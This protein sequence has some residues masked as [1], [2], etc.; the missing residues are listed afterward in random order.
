MAADTLQQINDSVAY[1]C[2][3]FNISKEESKIIKTVYNAIN[4]AIS[5]NASQ[6]L[7]GEFRVWA[8]YPVYWQ[9]ILDK[10]SKKQKFICISS[11]NSPSIED[12]F[13][14]NIDEFNRSNTFSIYNT[15]NYARYKENPNFSYDKKR[16][17]LRMLFKKFNNLDP[18]NLYEYRYLLLW[19][20]LLGSNNDLSKKVFDLN[21]VNLR[22][23]CLLAHEL[24]ES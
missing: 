1:L 21:T 16:E 10:K 2:K 9:M 18:Q 17:L 7:H 13:F 15:V 14:M 4:D 23:K 11:I 6:K 3:Q 24:I 22:E 8:R 19:L 12:F 5:F 20:I